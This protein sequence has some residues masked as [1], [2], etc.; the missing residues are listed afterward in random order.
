T[1]AGKV[2]LWE[3]ATGKEVRALGGKT[4]GALSAAFLPSNKQVLFANCSGLPKIVDLRTGKIVRTIT[5]TPW[6]NSGEAALSPGG[7]RVLFFLDEMLVLWDLKGGEEIRTLTGSHA[8]GPT[9][10]FVSFSLGRKNLLSASH[11][12][13]ICWDGSTGKAIK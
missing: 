6:S 4:P 1:A 3:V 10:G 11:D 7:S 9:I 5:W 2:K 12:S 13:L 8:E